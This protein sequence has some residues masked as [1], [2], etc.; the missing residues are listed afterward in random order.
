MPEDTERVERLRDPR[1]GFVAYTPVGS[2]AKGKELVTTG[3]GKTI[4]CSVCHG[5][6]LNGLGLVPGIAG[7][8]P[9]YMMRQLYDIKAGSRVG[10]AAALMQPVVA[11]ITSYN[12]CYTKLLR[13]LKYRPVTQ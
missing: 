9:S 13:V 5:Q 11:R 4:Q 12:V 7:R 10:A 1:L 2:L 6:D 3:G 8:S